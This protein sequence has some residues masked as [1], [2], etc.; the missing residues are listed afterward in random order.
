MN[1]HAPMKYR[2]VSEEDTPE[3]CL[4]DVEKRE[5]TLGVMSD[6]QVFN[7]EMTRLFSMS[8]NFIGHTSELPNAGDFVTRYVGSDPVIAARQKD[9]SVRVFANRCTHKGTAL[10]R[11]DRGRASKFICPYHGFTFNRDGSFLSMP[12]KQHLYNQTEDGEYDLPSARVEIMNEL[13]FANFDDSAPSFGESIGAYSSIMKVTFGRDPAG[14]EVIGPPQRWRVK[15]NWKT[16]AEQFSGDGYHTMTAHMSVLPVENRELASQGVDVSVNGN[17]SRCIDLAALV[18]GAAAKDMNPIDALKARPPAGMTADMIDFFATITTPEEIDILVNYPPAVGM[19][20]PNMSFMRSQ[21]QVP[22]KSSFVTYTD[23]KLARP[24]SANETEIWAWGLIEKSSTKEH[25]ADALLARTLLFGP[26]GSVERD[27]VDM[28]TRIQYSV[29]GG[30][31]R[32]AKAKYRSL[33]VADDD[34]LIDGLKTWRGFSGEN[35]SWEFFLRWRDFMNNA[36]WS[37]F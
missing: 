17:G 32:M 6:E 22:A 19:L 35:T 12:L 27:D 14:M 13:I 18:S 34:D 1:V 21:I 29:D 26:T 15:A 2:E 23:I 36:A 20:F 7:A 5:V 33:W 16:V 37:D 11:E 9:G 28:W 31:G 30:M 10:C 24:V 25:N 3:A 4:V 8:W